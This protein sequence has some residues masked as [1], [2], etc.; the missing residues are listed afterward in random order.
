MVVADHG[1]AFAMPIPNML[2]E[3]VVRSRPMTFERTIWTSS[4]TEELPGMAIL[5]LDAE[6]Y[7]DRVGAA[8]V[9]GHLERDGSLPVVV[10][11][12]VSNNGSTA[13]H[14]DFICQ[15]D[16]AAFIADDV[17][18]WIRARYPSVRGIVLAGL[19]LSGLAAAFIATRFPSKF[20]AT[21]CQSPSFWW[22]DGRFFKELSPPITPAG[23]L[24]VSVGD[25]ETEANVSHPPSGLFQGM[26]QIEGCD[27]A[28][29][30]LQQ[31]G[32]NVSYRTFTGGHDPDCWREDLAFALIWAC[33]HGDGG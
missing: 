25:R 13:R 8:S 23:K 4:S 2:V 7:L 3:H 10:S 14:A 24:W 30:A 1:A 15:A 11:V 26:S 17:T 6:L 32:Y 29:S 22:D 28:C 9:V 20:A 19:S 12:F 33:R 18:A 31:Y 5:F 21:I 27:A 16:Y